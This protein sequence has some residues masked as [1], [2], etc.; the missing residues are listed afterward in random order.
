MKGA[1]NASGARGWYGQLPDAVGDRIWVI[2]FEPFILALP[3]LRGRNDYQLLHAL[4]ERWM[5]STYTFHLPC[6][7]FTIDPVSFAAI[8]GI[9][10]A[11]DL[12]PFDRG[13]DMC[14][15]DHIAYIRQLLGMVPPL[16][17]TR[18]IKFDAIMS[19]YTATRVESMTSPA[20][21]DQVA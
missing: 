10:C 1:E 11:R 3:S 9:A 20:Q 8:T 4:M 21:I 15:R 5:D 2:G 17:G 18:T 12:V 7:E 14:S 13:L 6:S 16:K 19:H